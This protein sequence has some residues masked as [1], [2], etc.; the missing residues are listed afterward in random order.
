M[1]DGIPACLT[2]PLSNGGVTSR[3]TPRALHLQ[4]D[5]VAPVRDAWRGGSPRRWTSRRTLAL[6][7]YNWIT[8]ITGG[9]IGVGR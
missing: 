4:P 3:N 7:F 9:P 2:L 5:N 6:P 8:P 1:N